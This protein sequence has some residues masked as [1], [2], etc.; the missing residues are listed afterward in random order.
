MGHTYFPLEP[1]KCVLSASH[2][3][4]RV[5]LLKYKPRSHGSTHIFLPLLIFVFTLIGTS[6]ACYPG[7]APP[8]TPGPFP[9]EGVRQITSDFAYYQDLLWYP[10]NDLIAATRCPVLNFEPRCFEN[11]ETVL[12]YPDTGSIQTIN[13]QSIT[14]NRVSA[15]PVI[16]SPDGAKLLLYSREH[17]YTENDPSSDVH[18]RYIEYA[19]AENTFSEMDIAGNAIAW[20]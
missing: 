15:Y 1:S 16:W 2:E 8:P 6:L 10:N 20:S 3:K 7:L 13:F 17:F 14:S 5:V 9:V 19:P 18:S 4:R 11:E 12:I